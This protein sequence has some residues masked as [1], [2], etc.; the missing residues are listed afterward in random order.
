MA[1]AAKLARTA[2]TAGTVAKVGKGGRAVL[3]GTG[4]GAVAVVAE[5][6]AVEGIKATTGVEVQDP[7]STGFQYGAAIFDKD[8]T[9]ADVA[10]Q[11]RAHHRENF[12]NLAETLTT[13]GKV[14]DNI[15]KY[16]DSKN[17]A[18]GQG[19]R[20]INQFDRQRRALLEEHTGIKTERRMDIVAKYG[21]GL[22]K[23][24]LKGV[25]TVAG[26]RAK[27]HFENTKAFVNKT[28]ETSRKVGTAT[29]S[30]VGSATGA[31]LRSL[32]ETRNRYAAAATSD[33][34]VAAVAEV[35]KQRAQ[36][37]TNNAKKVGSKIAC[38][39][40]NIFTRKDKDKDCKK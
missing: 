2:K 38:G 34:P 9:I 18:L 21:A 11:R 5:M 39:I 37:H 13:E 23:D 15:T 27:H 16:A 26:E 40:G 6:A 31:D 25:A 10:A 24:G 36:H 7:L 32:R 4:V 22:K 8:V 29:R 1:R 30:T 14:M 19:V 28:Q 12:K 3:A 17:P 20:L 33:K 35:A